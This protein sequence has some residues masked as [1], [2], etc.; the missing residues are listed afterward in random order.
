M[1]IIKILSNN[2]TANSYVLVNGAGE[3]VLIDCGDS[4]ILNKVPQGVKIKTLILTHGHFDHLC[5]AAECNLRGIKIGCY[6]DE[7]DIA[8]NHNAGDY[9]GVDVPS[10]HIDF[11]FSEGETE[12]NGIKINVMHTPGHTCGSVCYIVQNSIFSGDTLFCGGAG[13]TDLYSGSSLE[14]YSSIKKLFS[15]SG[16]YAVYPGHGAETTIFAEKKNYGLI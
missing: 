11:T 2:F 10:F 12:L 1:E 8:L 6:K 4:A 5:G 16:D 3:G 9:F 15:L 14:L 7:K 13:R